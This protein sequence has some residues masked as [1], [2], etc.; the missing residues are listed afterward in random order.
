[1]ESVRDEILAELRQ[2]I[3]PADDS[4]S[5]YASW[6]R[7]TV[8]LPDPPTSRSSFPS[9]QCRFFD[10]HGFL[11]IPNFA[12]RDE[13]H[14]MKTSMANL[15]QNEWNPDDPS[16]PHSMQVFRTD[17]K[18]IEA[19]GRSDYFLDS[20]TKI[21]YFA[22]KDALDDGEGNH[23]EAKLKPEYRSENKIA[24]LNKA[25]HGMHIVPGPFRDYTQSSKIFNLL[26]ELGWTHPVVPQSMYIF[27]QGKIGGEVTSH[28]DST[29]LYTTPRQTCIGLW[30]ALDDA[31]LENGCLWVRPGSHRESVRR[32]FVRNPGHF[33]ESLEYGSEGKDEE[34]DRS[35]PQMV[36]RDLTEQCNASDDGETSKTIS[37]EG[38]LPANSLP[39][40]ECKGLYDAGFV[41]VPCKAGDLLAF[42]GKLDHL[43]L[44]N[45]SDRAR[46]T[47][48]LHCVEG[49][50]AGVRWSRE[51]WLQYP[52]GMEFMKL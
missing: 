32:Q 23:D 17:Q 8:S 25:G 43:S 42:C 36:F 50:D 14:S 18:Q 10:Q 2:Q 27:K 4:C 11:Y 13:V 15:V 30:L 9:P 29:F 37:W 12:S 33:G 5:K 3:P 19:Q 48:Q 28:Q 46:H 6:V 51:N 16:S 38:T 49:D 26:R 47:F 40:P 45:F 1:M 41:P 44:P 39:I 22:E 24:A 20:A 35:Q 7:G 21:H 34:G 52:K 31:T